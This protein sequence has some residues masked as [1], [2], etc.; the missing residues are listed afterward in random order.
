MKPL[1]KR[2][3]SKENESMYSFL[4]R[5]VVANYYDN[6]PSMLKEISSHLFV[7]NCN[8]LDH[9][10]G[11]SVIFMDVFESLNKDIHTF[12]LNQY[13]E[14]LLQGTEE[15][16][17]RKHEDRV[18]QKYSTKYCPD[19]LNEDYYHRLLWDVSL[20]TTCLKHNKHLIENCPN[21]NKAVR[22]NRLM[23][24]DCNCGWIF[25]RSISRDIDP[26][27]NVYKNQKV[28]QL[29]LSGEM[30]ETSTADNTVLNRQ[31]YFKFLLMFLTLIDGMDINAIL[32][33]TTCQPK[34]KINFNKRQKADKRNCDLINVMI[35]V[36]HLLVTRP[37]ILLPNVIQQID[38]YSIDSRNLK[39]NH[40]KKIVEHE[41]GRSYL[42][43]YSDYLNTVTNEY[44]GERIK[45][46]P[47]IEEKNYLTTGEAIKLIK[48]EDQVLKNLIHYGLVS[49]HKTKTKGGRTI[50]LVERK[51]IESYM[52]MKK[53]SYTLSQACKILGLNFV[54]AQELITRGHIKAQHGPSIDGYPIWYISKRELNKFI[55][56]VF[57]KVKIK[58]SI[59]SNWIPFEKANM[60]LRHTDMDTVSIIEAIKNGTF[61]AAI[62]EKTTNIKSIHLAK[63]DIDNFL[64]MLIKQRIK[65]YGLKP[66]ELLKIFKVGMPTINKWIKEGKLQVSMNAENANTTVSRY[67]AV[68]EVISMLMEKKKLS[69]KD[70]KFYLKKS[71]MEFGAN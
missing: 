21:C 65:Q 18:Y 26:K 56:S 13:D 39:Y 57:V 23:V 30:K 20:V 33:V 53:N 10:E 29:I 71:I 34:P 15:V 47:I 25:N 50:T 59:D 62:A 44:I 11:W 67:I 24:G 61:S 19:C 37:N 40:L 55:Q 60:N 43:V 31:E 35:S 63:R 2:V 32:K 48:T 3:T 27:S 4:Y 58:S 54:K 16:V 17:G 45:I 36:A 64:L 5:T 42:L 69:Y 12:S 52:K 14:L 38:G 51:S 28:L 68:N 41:K 6:L 7:A 70:A 8:Y 46:K 1:L 49:T 22:I 9:K 66:R